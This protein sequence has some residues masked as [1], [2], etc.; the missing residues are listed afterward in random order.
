[1]TALTSTCISKEKEGEEAMAR[2]VAIF[3]LALMPVLAGAQDATST[4]SATGNPAETLTPEQA[5]AMAQH[6][7]RQVKTAFQSV[8]QANEQIL[9][10][11]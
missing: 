11:N 7:N 6:D 10:A 3:L 4:A 9:A 2:T 5:V 8:L 1:L